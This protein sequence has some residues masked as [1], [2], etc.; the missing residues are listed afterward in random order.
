MCHFCPVEI[1]NLRLGAG[2]Y[3]WAERIFLVLLLVLFICFTCWQQYTGKKVKYGFCKTMS[4]EN[5]KKHNCIQD[6]AS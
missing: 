3:G 6:P 5:M 2:S 4:N 1:K